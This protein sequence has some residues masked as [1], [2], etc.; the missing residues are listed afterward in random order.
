MFKIAVDKGGSN[1]TQKSGW[2]GSTP[3]STPTVDFIK[4][5]GRIS[6]KVKAA[7]SS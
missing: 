4:N 3:Q 1:Q 7:L 5:I 2:A 6:S